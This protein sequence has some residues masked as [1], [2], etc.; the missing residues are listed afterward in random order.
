[1]RTIR[2]DIHVVGV[3]ARATNGAVE[4]RGRVGVTRL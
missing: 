3:E 2:R 4:R 1:V